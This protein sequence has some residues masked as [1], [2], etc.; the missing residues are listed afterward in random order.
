[1]AVQFDQGDLGLGEFTRDYYLDRERHGEKIAAYR[2]FLIDKVTQFLHD[3][4]LP[5]NSTKIASDVDEIIDLETKWAE[6]IVPE[7][8][9]RDYSRMYNLRR[10]NDMQEVMPLVDWTRYF[11]SVAPYV[12][13]DYFA[14]NPEIV[15]REVD[16]MKKLGEFLQSTDPRI[17][18]NYI[19]MRY[20]SS[21]NGELG[22]KYEDISQ[23]F[24]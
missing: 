9:R 2:K 12:V 5:T 7:E 14:S 10:L 6:I 13:H 11:N 17:I 1:M 23:V 4:D 20:T 22:E 8:N 18:T 15:I 19:Y 3:A 21:W 16:Y 24:I